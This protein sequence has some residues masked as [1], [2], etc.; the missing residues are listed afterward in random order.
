M[1]SYEKFSQNLTLELEI[2]GTK[3]LLQRYTEIHRHV[4]SFFSVKKWCSANVFSNTKRKNLC[5]KICKMRKVFG[6]ALGTYYFQGQV[7]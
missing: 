1:T 3:L 6:C 7:S 5:W 4:L 2:S